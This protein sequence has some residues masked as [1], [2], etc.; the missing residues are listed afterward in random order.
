MSDEKKMVE[1][2]T[3]VAEQTRES[4]P[5]TGAS[6]LKRRDLL[7]NAGIGGVAAATYLH[8]FDRSRMRALA[9][10]TG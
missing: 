8:G 1:H 6:G 3:P 5:T 4:S 10:D 7:R 9:Q 2:V